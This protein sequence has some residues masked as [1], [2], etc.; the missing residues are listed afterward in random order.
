MK[1]FSLL[2][3]FFIGLCA[4]DVSRLCAQA[5]G[6]TISGTLSDSTGAPRPNATITLENVT[7]GQRITATTDNHGFYRIEGAPAGR[8]RVVSTATATSG[9]PAQ[10]VTI[11]SGSPT[12]VNL[13]MA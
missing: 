7:T 9:T 2:L 12:T 4:S 1:K 11:T 13:T 8:Y 3:L 6:G 5:T 10:E